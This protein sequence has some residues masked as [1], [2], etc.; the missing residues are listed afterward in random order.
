M[1]GASQ[2]PAST[3]NPQAKGADGRAPGTGRG[4][5]I[6]S[7]TTRAAKHAA[8]E[9]RAGYVAPADGD[10]RAQAAHA[11][12]V[13]L[14]P[15]VEVPDAPGPE[16][17]RRDAP[18]APPVDRVAA[19]LNLAAIMR[20]PVLAFGFWKTLK[21]NARA[22]NP[23]TVRGV[24]DAAAQKLAERLP[25][26]FLGHWSVDLAGFALDLAGDLIASAIVNF[27]PRQTVDGQVL[28][29]EGARE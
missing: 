21:L 26:G 17:A 24:T 28:A 18:E 5:P 12:L 25:A 29:P 9:R 22:M 3:T 19:A 6:S 14:A 8:P 20:A 2:D 16:D 1:D 4:R 10:A 7:K 15:V 11:A 27:K 23:E 13:D